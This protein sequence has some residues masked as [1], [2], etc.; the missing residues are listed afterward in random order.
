MVFSFLFNEVNNS[1]RNDTSRL[2]QTKQLSRNVE[3][4]DVKR[5]GLWKK[6]RWK[7][8]H[9]SIYNRNNTEHTHVNKIEWGELFPSDNR[10]VMMS[11]H[12]ISRDVSS[13]TS[14]GPYSRV[15]TQLFSRVGTH[16]IN[17]PSH[18]QLFLNEKLCVYCLDSS[19]CVELPIDSRGSESLDQLRTL[20]V[21]LIV[22][23]ERFEHL[24]SNCI[25]SALMRAL[26][27]NITIW[28]IYTKSQTESSSGLDVTIGWLVNTVFGVQIELCLVELV[29]RISCQ[30]VTVAPPPKS[31]SSQLFQLERT[32][33]QSTR[34]DV[35][36][37]GPN[38]AGEGR[39]V[40]FKNLFSATKPSCE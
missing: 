28:F 23:R 8:T 19:K 33:Y 14:F 17:T 5:N 32:K 39:S 1:I 24:G 37:T 2:G 18:L 4:Y 25:P 9:V 21:P 13:T 27:T 35:Q 22:S 7:L 20:I 6:K 26:W 30:H 34:K 16:R 38:S 12:S 40:V 10:I 15:N 36:A 3:N 31:A 11:R 29:A